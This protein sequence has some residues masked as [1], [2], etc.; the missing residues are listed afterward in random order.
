MYNNRT[1]P[2]FISWQNLFFFFLGA[3][4]VAAAS[5]PLGFRQ[6]FVGE[7]SQVSAAFLAQLDYLC[8]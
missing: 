3:G 8:I 1:E 7:N 5:L 4:T 6:A 2:L